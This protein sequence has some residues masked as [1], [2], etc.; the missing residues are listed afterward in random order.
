MK[1]CQ[2]SPGFTFH[3]K[4]MTLSLN[5]KCSFEPQILF[6][7]YFLTFTYASIYI[8]RSVWCVDQ[9]GIDQMGHY[10]TVDQL[11]NLAVE[12]SGDV[13]VTLH[14]ACRLPSTS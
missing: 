14:H 8:C 11:I 7:I 1:F 2:Y 5:S 10:C 13:Q 3:P 4:R 12:Q 6:S 9:F